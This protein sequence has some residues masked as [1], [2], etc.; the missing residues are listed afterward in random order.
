MS[1]YLGVLNWLLVGLA[2]T[3]LVLVASDFVLARAN[4]SLQ[5][6]IGQREQFIAEGVRLGR[7]REALIKDIADAV[8]SSNDSRLRDLLARQGISIGSPPAAPAGSP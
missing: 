3:T 1:R 4:R 6:E 2:A 8:V 5:A 7:V